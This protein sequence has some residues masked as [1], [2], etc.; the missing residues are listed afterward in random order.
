MNFKLIVSIL[1]FL[2]MC[3]GIAML[4]PIPF[5]LHYGDAD[6]NALLVSSAICVFTGIL[7]WRV[8]RRPGEELRVRDGFLIVTLGWI[9]VSLFGSIPF[10]ISGAVPSFTDAFFETMSGFTTTGASILRDVE[11]LPHGILFWRSFTHWMGGMG[12][13]VLSLAVLPFLGIAGMQLYKAEAA[14]PTKD[15]LSPRIGET[16]RL[17]WGVYVLLTV[18]EVIFLR[19]GG[20]SLFDSLCHAFGTIATGGFSTKNSSIGFYKSAYVDAVVTVF[21]FLS[22]MNFALHYAALSGNI[23]AYLR[24]SEW[25]FFVM[26]LAGAVCVVTVVNFVHGQYPTLLESLRFSAFNVVSVSTCT[27]FATTDFALWIPAAQ[28]VLLLLMFPG[29]CA[30]STSGAIKQVR[31]FLLLRNTLTELK[32]LIHPKAVVP[33]RFCGQPV[34]PEILSTIAAFFATYVAVF[35]IASL[36]MTILGLDIVSA[37]SATATCMA[38]CGPG[39]GSVGPMS[40]YADVPTIGKWLLS[41]C[42]LLGRLELFTVFVIFTKAFWRA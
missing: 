37:V 35:A 30:G 38:G 17:L 39:L 32:K 36:F 24:N 21:M 29:G 31:V 18:L 3:V 14:G 11:R 42:M 27:G 15:K 5:S 16:A 12:I 10:M 2:I 25:K 13:I 34:E 7:L 1:G 4:A 23:K 22:A 6:V 8:F 26:V 41:V 40:N 20:M 33:V 9:S 28:I 19:I